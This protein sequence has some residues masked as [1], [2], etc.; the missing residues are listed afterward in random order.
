MT[1]KMITFEGQKYL[2]FGLELDFHA[3]PVPGA[4]IFFGEI[5]N[6]KLGWKIFFSQEIEFQKI[7]H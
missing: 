1:S 5:G 7:N 4:E 2:K 6:Y 3:E